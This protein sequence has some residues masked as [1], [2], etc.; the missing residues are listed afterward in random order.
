MNIDPMKLA[1]YSFTAMAV[2]ATVGIAATSIAEFQR[3]QKLKEGEELRQEL[4]RTSLK[5]YKY[6]EDQIDQA[7][8]NKIVRDNDL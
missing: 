4:N 6:W 5:L 2:T 3:I 1:I 7:K 8:F